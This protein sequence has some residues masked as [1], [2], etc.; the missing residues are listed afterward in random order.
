MRFV[1]NELTVLTHFS[2]IALLKLKDVFK[3]TDKRYH[4]LQKDH[5][6]PNSSCTLLNIAKQV[7]ILGIS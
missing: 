3:Q 4:T 2:V 1:L 5:P 7:L 6:A